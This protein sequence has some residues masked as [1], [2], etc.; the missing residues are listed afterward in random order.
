M[1]KADPR[2]LTGGREQKAPPEMRLMKAL[3]EKLFGS[4]DGKLVLDDLK[5]R[6]T[7]REM[8]S[9]E[10]HDMVYKA[11][12]HDVILLIDIMATPEKEQHD[13]MV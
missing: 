2:G 13:G 3:Y 6:F 12:Q 10:A 11:G 9:P 8:R 4:P 5:R 1:S 7:R